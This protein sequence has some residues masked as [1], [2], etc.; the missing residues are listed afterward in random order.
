M[1]A[2][3]GVGR[4]SGGYIG[5]KTGESAFPAAETME[6]YPQLNPGQLGP[7]ETAVYAVMATGYL[8]GGLGMAKAITRYQELKEKDLE[9]TRPFLKP[10]EGLRK[11]REVLEEEDSEDDVSEGL[12]LLLEE[13]E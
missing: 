2:G 9:Y 3:L 12:E 13:D 7:E 4:Y 8:A 1:Y 10:V 6:I 11:A 5:F